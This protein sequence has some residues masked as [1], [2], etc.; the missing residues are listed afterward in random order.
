MKQL[1]GVWLPDDEQHLE[2]FLRRSQEV[3]PG[4]DGSYQRATWMM[5]QKLMAEQPLR[6]RWAVDV[7][8]HVGLWTKLIAK[9]FEGVLAFEPIHKFA[10]CWH[11]NMAGIPNVALLEVGLGTHTHLSSFKVEAGNSGATH[12]DVVDGNATGLMV[13]LDDLQLAGLDFLKIDV[14]GYELDALI[15]AQETV[16]EFRPLV[17]VE[18]K[19]HGRQGNQYDALE[20]LKEWGMRVRVRVQDDWILDWRPA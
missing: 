8:A 15:G 14:E 9:D 1:Y 5:C 12:Q 7:G 19:D 11:R 2:D 13:A 4:E 17:C 20:M 3:W 16:R 18:Q 10:E 6:R